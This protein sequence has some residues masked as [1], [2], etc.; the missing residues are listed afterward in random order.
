M[1]I[2]KMKFGNPWLGEMDLSTIDQNPSV[3]YAQ[4]NCWFE[5][6]RKLER[7]PEL[8][9]LGSAAD[10]GYTLKEIVPISESVPIG[11]ASRKVNFLL[12]YSDA[13]GKIFIQAV[14]FE[15]DDLG[16]YSVLS[17]ITAYLTP[18]TSPA[19]AL[20]YTPIRLSSIPGQQL[21]LYRGYPF[22]IMAESGLTLNSTDPNLSAFIPWMGTPLTPTGVASDT[23]PGALAQG[24]H[25]LKYR[26]ELR[27][28]SGI[29]RACTNWTPSVQVQVGVNQDGITL[30]TGYYWSTTY[31]ISTSNNPNS[32]TQSVNWGVN[33][34]KVAANPGCKTYLVVA[35]SQVGYATPFYVTRE[36]DCQDT[37]GNN[38]AITAIVSADGVAETDDWVSI[39]GAIDIA[40]I[41][42][43]YCWI[44]GSGGGYVFRWGNAEYP[45]LA[46][47]TDFII[48]SPD[49]VIVPINS[50]TVA[51]V[52]RDT[53]RYLQNLPDVPIV[54]EYAFPG[55]IVRGAFHVVGD[56]VIV[57]TTRGILYD[58]MTRE[59]ISDAIPHFNE[60]FDGSAVC[61]IAT[62]K[63]NI[64]SVQTENTAPAE[65]LSSSAKK[66]T[67]FRDDGAW[68]KLPDN[69][70]I[71]GRVENVFGSGVLWR[72]LKVANGYE[73]QTRP[74][75]I[76]STHNQT[77]LNDLDSTAGE[78]PYNASWA[79]AWQTADSGMLKDLK[80]LE[81]IQEVDSQCI[82]VLE[83]SS[84]G[85]NAANSK[86]FTFQSPREVQALNV[87]GKFFRLTIKSVTGVLFSVIEA[88]L[89]YEIS[90][91]KHGIT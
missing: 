47:P 81:I 91:S 63:G 70:F 73:I 15:S 65:H 86:T 9:T 72:F 6:S 50:A 23:N 83:T 19:D 39:T 68:W 33:Q 82:V 67:A 10:N 58:V 40:S 31:G 8:R 37:Y 71:L 17:P 46:Y 16:L 24:T 53:V 84:D 13:G 5:D 89:T 21:V 88:R 62:K 36:I 43:V 42:G 2:N 64:T 25:Y 75:T 69:S 51:L 61:G 57:R 54:Q 55:P 26:F 44:I 56:R 49:E 14:C 20:N 59:K 85:K 7:R 66:S 34:H 3:A 32:W 80:G 28:A 52:G 90:T 74:H 18:T 1:A 78:T 35:K 30:T 12:I 87:S 41:N 11:V 38:V 79:S 45:Y 29:M 4:T 76:D 27:D 48:S 60:T 22:I 77:P